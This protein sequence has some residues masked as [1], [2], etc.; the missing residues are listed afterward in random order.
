MTELKKQF[1]LV[2]GWAFLVLAVAG[3]FLPVLP[4]TPFVLAAS[5]C[6][7]R[8]SATLHAALKQNRWFGPILENW[9]RNKSISRRA[10]LSAVLTIALGISLSVYLAPV[11][12][13]QVG[14]VGVGLFVSLYIL[15]RPEPA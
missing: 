12:A 4:T 5:Y 14:L 9:E 7:A 6:F 3:V 13:V 8:S 2:C 15:T 10:K 11:F 1:F